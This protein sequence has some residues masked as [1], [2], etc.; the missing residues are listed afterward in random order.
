[1]P[2]LAGR[3]S[4]VWKIKVW[5][6]KKEKTV[7]SLYSR[8]NNN[9]KRFEQ[10]AVKVWRWKVVWHVVG[11]GDNSNQSADDSCDDDDSNSSYRRRM[12]NKRGIFPKSATSILKAWLFQNLAVRLYIA[13]VDGA[14][15][16]GTAGGGDSCM[17]SSHYSWNLQLIANHVYQFNI[18]GSN[19]ITLQ[20]F[21]SKFSDKWQLPQTSLLECTPTVE[22]SPVVVPYVRNTTRAFTTTILHFVFHVWTVLNIKSFFCR[23]TTALLTVKFVRFF[24]RNIESEHFLPDRLTAMN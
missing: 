17:S 13:I 19:G 12:K 18:K 2:I 3:R 5:V 24:C 6:T 11:A 14:V 20:H 22:C 23:N 15:T 16:V 4:P 8:I 10:R 21:I 1:M 7:G 9:A